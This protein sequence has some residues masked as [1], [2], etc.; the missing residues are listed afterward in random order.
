M[1]PSQLKAF[2]WQ[3]TKLNFFILLLFSLVLLFFTDQVFALHEHFYGGTLVA[4]KRDLYLI[5][6]VFKLLWIFFNAIPY[7]ALRSM[8][9][10]A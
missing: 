3:C 2:L 9:K 10:A 5:M 6:G 7:W 4:F 1:N 8:E